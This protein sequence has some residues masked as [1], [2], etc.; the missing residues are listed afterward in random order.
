MIS[1]LFILM[2]GF[3]GS[4]CAGSPFDSALEAYFSDR[5]TLPAQSRLHGIRT[6]Y[7][8]LR[9]GT[10]RKAA[11]AFKKVGGRLQG[12]TLWAVGED[13]DSDRL[14]TEEAFEGLTFYP[15]E[16]KPSNRALALYKRSESPRRAFDYYSEIRE[17]NSILIERTLHFEE[18]HYCLYF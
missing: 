5:A 3:Q 2:T 4:A 16:P 9:D 18:E 13:V 15:L 1:V 12:L 17:V 7:C 10:K 8:V 6:G 14:F 11:L